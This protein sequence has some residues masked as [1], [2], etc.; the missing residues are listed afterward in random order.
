MNSL[1]RASQAGFSL[2]LALVL[3]YTGYGLFIANNP[4][5]RETYYQ[6]GNV[7]V[8]AP[9]GCPKTF[10]PLPQSPGSHIRK[11]TRLAW[12][13]F[14]SLQRPPCGKTQTI[15][16]P[17]DEVRFIP[18]TV[19]VLGATANLAFSFQCQTNVFPIYRELRNR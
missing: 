5:E 18:A 14:P 10:V 8:S 12:P 11:L 6:E 1:E 4:A 3:A 19:H 16:P 13:A 7:E 2:L 17:G 15:P 9:S